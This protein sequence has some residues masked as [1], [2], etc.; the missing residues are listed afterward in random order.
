[1]PEV[2]RKYIPGQPDFLPY[3]K[4]L[5]KDST[6]LKAKGAAPGPKTKI[7]QPPA[8]GAGAAADKMKDLKV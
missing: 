5:P 8:G 7:T 2:L 3:T 1:M 4:E 6:S